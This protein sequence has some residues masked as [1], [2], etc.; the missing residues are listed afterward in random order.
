MNRFS[1]FAAWMVVG[2]GALITIGTSRAPTSGLMGTFDRTLAAGETAHVT[3]H[4][5]QP[6]MDH[7]RA[8]GGTLRLRAQTSAGGFTVVPDGMEA[9]MSIATGGAAGSAVADDTCPATGGCDVGL[10]LEGPRAGDDAVVRVFLDVEVAA[11]NEF[12]AGSTVTAEED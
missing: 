2:L 3:F 9:A 7:V 8:L 5:S 12:P 1:R 4:V 6:A 10:T 11:Q